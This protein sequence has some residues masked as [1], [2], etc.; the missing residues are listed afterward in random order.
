M[1]QALEPRVYLVGAGPGQPD[2]LTVRAAQLLQQA[3]VIFYDQLVPQRLLDWAAPTAERI[4]IHDFPGTHAEKTAQVVQRMIA[5]ARLGRN[6]VRLKGGDP[7]IFGRGG[8][9]IEALRQAGIAYEVVPGITAALAAGAYLEIPLT[10][11]RHASAV[12]FVTG[13]E[14]S[15]KQS[16]VD[17]PLLARFPGTLVIYMGLN[18][19]PQIVAALL[20][21]GRAPNTPAALVS[22]VTWSQQ[23][24]V[25]TRLA[26]LEKARCEAGIEAPALIIIGEAVR[27]SRSQSWSEQRPLFGQQVLVTRPQEQAMG[28]IQRLEQLGAGVYHWPAITIAEPSDAEPLDQA[29]DQ[30]RQG[31]WDWLVF[32]SVNGVHGLIRRLWQRGGDLRVLRCVQLAA[33]GP[34][35]AEALEKYHLRADVVPPQTYSSEG[36]LAA[37]IPHVRGQRVLLARADQGRELL[38]DGLLGI[39]AGV[40]QVVVYEQRPAPP[41]P[42]WLLDAL[43]RGAIQWVTLT[44]SNIAH[45]WLD[46]CDEIIR[47]HICHNVIGLIAISPETGRV[48]RQAGLPVAA[49]AEVYT[50]EGIIT[51]LTHAVQRRRQSMEQSVKY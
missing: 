14:C 7:L 34:K 30:L 32:T 23:R 39:A 35:T 5:A 6:V 36:L 2:L 24:S 16:A 45:R 27:C 37:L 9:E 51:A 3:D 50:E 48:L 42:S 46:Y 28:L 1:E 13:H 33:I 29:L 12:A 26:D 15:E 8:E 41:P 19:L 11:R 17:W 31:Q 49:E 20:Q 4:C 10:H 43:R 44:S 38:R 18:R 22:R 25:V 21:A 40:Q 47:R